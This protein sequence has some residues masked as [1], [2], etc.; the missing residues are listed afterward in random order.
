MLYREAYQ[1]VKNA[2]ILRHWMERSIVER[3]SS[4]GGQRGPHTKELLKHFHKRIME[5]ARN[6]LNSSDDEACVLWQTAEECYKEAICPRGRL[7]SHDYF[8]WIDRAAE[9][10]C[11]HENRL[12]EDGHHAELWSRNMEVHKARKM[13]ERHET[14]QNWVEFWV[15]ALSNCPGGPTRFYPPAACSAARSIEGPPFEDIPR[16]LF[17]AF[18]S[19]GSGKTEDNILASTMSMLGNSEGS[20]VDILSLDTHSALEMLYN[21]LIKDCFGGSASDNLMSWSSSLMCVIQY[22]IWR[23]HIGSLSPAEVRICVI[24]AAIFPPGQFVRDLTLLKAFNNM[25]LIEDQKE[26]FSFSSR[27]S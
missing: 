2:K 17:R 20:K 5:N 9:E 10:S 19:K 24:D 16:Y 6:V 4:L 22:A 26:F 18:D 11:E 25:E 1:L 15:R 14:G 27:E 13:K 21:H 8:Y 23:S 3:V 7:G 12:D